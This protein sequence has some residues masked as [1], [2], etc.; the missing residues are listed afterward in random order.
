MKIFTQI[1]PGNV[2]R[3]VFLLFV[4]GY[5]IIFASYV[6]NAINPVLLT[7]FF[8]FIFY[9]GRRLHL[10]FEI[11]MLVF[12]M[13]LVV[14]SFMSIDPRRSFYEIWVIGV[15][16]FVI[17]S[18][19]SLVKQ[20]L[21]RRLVTTVLLTIGAGFMVFS[22][23]DAA[24][25]YITWKSASLEGWMPGISYRL[26]GG[27]TIAAYYHGA[28]MI[29][30]AR[31][32]FSR[33]KIER[34][35]MGGYCLSALALIFL[36]SSRGAFLGVMGGFA[37]LGLYQRQALGKLIGR[38]RRLFPRYRFFFTAGAVM[39]LLSAV[40]IGYGYMSGLSG[41]PTHVRLLESRGVFWSP[42]WQGFWQNPL[43]GQGPYTYA[44]LFMHTQSIPP[45]AI[46]LH[47]HNMYLDL[48]SGS[49]LPGLLVFGWLVFAIYKTLIKKDTYETGIGDSSVYAG[50]VFAITAFLIHNIFDG[51][52]LMSFAGFNLCILLGAALAGKIKSST[53]NVNFLPL[54]LGLAV[55]LLA[56]L[57]FW[58]TQPYNQAIQMAENGHYDESADLFRTAIQRDGRL[59]VAHQ[60]LG[61]VESFRAFQGD[62]DALDL[63]IRTFEQ[64]IALE[65][66]YSVDHANLG[67]LYKTQGDLERARE[68]F[69][70]AVELAPRWGLYYLNL[71]D[72]LEMQGDFAGSAKA[73]IEAFSRHPEWVE[74]Y[75]WRSNSFRAGV[76]EEWEKE[77]P[78]LPDPVLTESDVTN[79]P[80]PTPI[81]ALAANKLK[82]KDYA[83]A[84]RLLDLAKLT[85]FGSGD[86]EQKME[87]LW[88][89][90]ELAAWRED[91][92][93]AVVLGEKAVNGYW[94]QGA[95][96][97]G[98]AG[99]SLYGPGIFRRDT[100]MLD[101]VPQLTVLRLP[102]PWEVRMLQL[103]EWHHLAGDADKCRVV[104]GELTEYAPD[105]EHRDHEKPGCL[106]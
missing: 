104:Y 17:Y 1:A 13:V 70:R 62:S 61:L 93:N 82:E 83:A 74:D 52:Y 100:I 92:H 22:W 19:A 106:L 68:E 44:S 96:G 43:F 101:L 53:D 76:V 69:Q 91:W 31:L 54:G 37:S 16:I 14:T 55:V 8:L 10:G 26:N 64:A 45:V 66:Y 85:Y 9:A 33:H 87:W 35:I 6:T 67:A 32:A 72:V 71:G 36:S 105:I 86:Q 41:H 102:G 75:F 58:M 18:T 25:W 81:L 30:F 15:G 2:L 20:G 29:A 77:N 94:V 5:L 89:E 27:N 99:M 51:L 24:K 65:P 7:G 11:P 28:L 12:T 63:A 38:A 57:N 42:A 98:G 80:R 40:G 23:I 34:F 84:E 59:A 21:P 50:A 49:G 103:S 48:L 3:G 56:W 46:F 47:A 90:A 73:Y 39:I 4:S 95:Y 97:P 60:Q 79:Q 78:A 88:L